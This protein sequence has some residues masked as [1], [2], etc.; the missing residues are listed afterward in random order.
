MATLRLLTVGPDR[1]TSPALRPGA[2]GSHPPARAAAQDGARVLLGGGLP[3]RSSPI[4]RPGKP[5][6]AHHPFTAPHPDDVRKLEQRSVRRAGRCTT[7]RST[8]AT[9]W[10]RARSASPIRR[11]SAPCF[12]HLGISAGGHRCAV[13]V[14]PDGARRRARRHTAASPSASTARRCCSRVRARCAT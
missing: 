6:F 7:T 14:P 3:A 11:C 9:S 1:V 13:R 12:R 2:P 5:V 4:R 8:T 10:V